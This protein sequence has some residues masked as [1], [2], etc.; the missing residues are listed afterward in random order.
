MERVTLCPSSNCEGSG[1][2]QQSIIIVLDAGFFFWFI[3]TVYHKMR[4]ILLQNATAIFLQNAKI[5][6]QNA[7]ILLQNATVIPKCDV[8]YKLP[9][10]IQLCSQTSSSTLKWGR[11]NDRKWRGR[12]NDRKWRGI[13]YWIGSV[14]WSL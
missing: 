13:P 2:I 8:Y 9:Q 4:Q 7:K 3:L 6:L 1:D 11:H 12:H 5:L 14:F 10:H